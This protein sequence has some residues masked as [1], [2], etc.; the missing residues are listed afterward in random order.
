MEASVRGTGLVIVH[1][2]AV[3]VPNPPLPPIPA[4]GP[5]LP[6]RLADPSALTAR[7]HGVLERTARQ[8]RE[9]DPDLRVST[10]LADGGRVRA[11]VD[12]AAD[13]QLVVLGRETRSGVERVLTGATTAGVASRARCPVVVVPGDWQPRDGAEDW[14]AIVVGIRRMADASDLMDAAYA[15][16]PSSRAS[17][18]V[19][20]AWEMADP[21][22]DRIEARTHADEWQSRGSRLLDEALADCR[23]HPDVPVVTSVV[24]GHAATVLA[25][26]AKSADLLV[27][28]RAHAHRPFDHLGTTVRALLLASPAP[29]VVVPARTHVESLPDLVLE[30]SGTFT[31]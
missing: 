17:I 29:V 24:H 5:V 7:A 31:R 9:Q 6:V 19:V 25:T 27:V 12:V 3:D 1:V 11:I 8:A 28:R 13:A 23:P 2:R 16:A 4:V 21:F 20:H 30:E 14:R 15:S 26:A 10:V 18:T 22:L